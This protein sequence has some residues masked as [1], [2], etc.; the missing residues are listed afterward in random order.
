MQRFSKKKVKASTAQRHPVHFDDKVV[1]DDDSDLDSDEEEA[2]EARGREMEEA[3]AEADRETAEQKRLRLAK[4]YLTKM[5][6]GDGA[7]AGN[8]SGDEDDDDDEDDGSDDEQDESDGDGER[9][10][11]VY[12][13]TH[14]RLTRHLGARLGT[15]CFP[16]CCCKSEAM[17]T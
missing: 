4:D 12:F 16:T 14:K 7:L 8:N 5:G 3:N 13:H 6:G 1:A 15:A 10:A 11:K 17:V 2:A 9:S